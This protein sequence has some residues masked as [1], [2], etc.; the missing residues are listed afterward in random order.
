[1]HTTFSGAT[2]L[3]TS[4][5]VGPQRSWLPMAAIGLLV[6]LTAVAPLA[7]PASAGQW[8]IEV[9]PAWMD[10]YG[11]DQHVMT[12]H[13]VDSQA[14]PTT[15]RR[16]GVALNTDA[17]FAYGLQASYQQD[18]WGIGL[19]LIRF[20]NSQVVP[21]ERRAA[22]GAPGSRVS[23]EV[24]NRTYTSSSPSEVLYYGTV[25]DTEFQ[26]WT[27]DLYGTVRLATRAHSRADLRLGVT[28]GDLD[29]DYRALVGID[30]VAGTR[31]DAPANYDR[32]IGPLV[33]LSGEAPLDRH[34]LRGG[35]A[36]ATLFGDNELTT[37]TRDFRGDPAACQ[38]EAEGCP[39][40]AYGAQE[41]FKK[42]LD[43]AIPVSKLQAWYSLRLSSMISLGVGLDATTW[44]DVPVQPGMV[45][46]EDGNDALQENTIVYWGHLGGLTFAF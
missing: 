5:P 2:E 7:P 22:N 40:T 31:L 45:P 36:L 26:T 42:E 37:S 29:N 10:A 20:L 35:M 9:R 27:L 39:S 24:A 15:D 13:E 18:D 25:A 32:M 41:S 16:T 46:E 11:H 1:M 38:Y 12:I 23:F 6:G 17:G 4:A 19:E 28:T 34:T 3:T 30:D 14:G 8:L 44:W 21:S 43:V 33:G